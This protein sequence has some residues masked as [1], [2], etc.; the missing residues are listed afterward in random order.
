MWLGIV[1]FKST[2]LLEK[3]SSKEGAP[4]RATCGGGYDL[5]SDMLLVYLCVLV[6]DPIAV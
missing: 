3:S 4:W 1:P 6:N 2:V 5:N